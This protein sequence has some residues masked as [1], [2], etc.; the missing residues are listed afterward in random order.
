MTRAA[1]YLQGDS[2][3]IEILECVFRWWRRTASSSTEILVPCGG[4]GMLLTV[5]S[6][7]PIPP[8]S[9]LRERSA[10]KNG[11]NTRSCSVSGIPGPSSSISM[12]H[13]PSDTRR[14]SRA[15][16]PYFTAF[17]T[18]LATARG[19]ATGSPCMGTD[20]TPSRVTSCPTSLRSFT[21]L[22]TSSRRSNR[23]RVPPKDRSRTKSSAA[24]IMSV[25]CWIS[26]STFSLS[27]KSSP[28][29]RKAKRVSGVRRS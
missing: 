15:L 24:E 26:N 18:R 23:S 27:G 16:P 6:P 4:T 13:F 25:I 20:S 11:S 14:C 17:S 12:T 5:V 3:S 21:T 29:R 28:S 7:N 10:R 22:S 19:S 1:T 8:V 2:G 9:R